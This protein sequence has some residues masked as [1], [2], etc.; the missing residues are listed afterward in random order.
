MMR[1]TISVLAS[2]VFC[3]LQTADAISQNGPKQFDLSDFF[4]DNTFY[5]PGVGEFRSMKDGENY[6][7]IEGKGTKLVMHS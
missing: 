5:S 7:S 1:K 4:R 3:L 2:F 6:I